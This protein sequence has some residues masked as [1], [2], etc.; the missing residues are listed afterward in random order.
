MGLIFSFSN[1][2]GVESTK[3]SDGF[4]IKVVENVLRKDLSSVEKEKWINCLVVPVR[5]GAHIGVYFVL[6]ILICSFISE[7]MIVN[8]KT[9]ILAIIIT[10]LYACSDEVHQLMIAGRSGQISDVII[11]TIGASVGVISFSF[12]VRK[13]SKNG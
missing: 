2:T 13:C 3:K 6:G 4:I 8:Y 10:F 9:I 5:K 7:F 1:D 12:I 11:D